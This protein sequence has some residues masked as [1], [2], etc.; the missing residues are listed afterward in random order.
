M[1]S[2]QKDDLTFVWS[3][4]D[5][6]LN[7]IGMKAGYNAASNSHPWSQK[8]VVVVTMCIQSLFPVRVSVSY[9]R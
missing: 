8:E 3:T 9:T 5:G 4:G 7:D 1:D 2:G 6:G